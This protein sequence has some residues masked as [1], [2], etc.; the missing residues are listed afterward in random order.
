MTSRAITACA[1]TQR[2]A[3]AA[4]RQS[5]SQVAKARSDAAPEVDDVRIDE[6]RVD[7]SHERRDLVVDVVE[8]LVLRVRV[9]GPQTAR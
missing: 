2:D 8:G 5:L 1:W 6:R 4:D 3:G 9:P 7:A